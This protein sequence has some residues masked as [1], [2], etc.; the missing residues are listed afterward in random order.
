MAYWN[1]IFK[2]TKAERH[3]YGTLPMKSQF[4]VNFQEKWWKAAND[5]KNPF[6]PLSNIDHYVWCALANVMYHNNTRGCQE[7]TSIKMEDFSIGIGTE[8][9]YAGIPYVQL[10]ANYDNQ[11]G[12][13]LTM[14]KN[15]VNAENS[16]KKCLPIPFDSHP[17]SCYKTIRTL[18]EWM[19]AIE[20]CT[21]TKAAGRRFFRHKASK[22]DLL[23]F[24]SMGMP[25]QL[26][27]NKNNVIGPN[28]VNVILK[29]IAK[30]CGYNNWERCTSHGLRR[31][32]LS[33]CANAGVSSAVMVQLGGHSAVPKEQKMTALYQKP[34]QQAY[35]QA[36]RA[37]HG[38]PS[39]IKEKLAAEQSKKF[40]ADDD[41][42]PDDFDLDDIFAGLNDFDFTA[43]DGK[44][45]KKPSVGFDLDKKPAAVD[46]KPPPFAPELPTIDAPSEE[47]AL[48]DRTNTPQVYTKHVERKL[49]FPYKP[50]P[51]YGHQLK[52]VRDQMAELKLKEQQ[53][54]QQQPPHHYRH[55][56][57][58]FSTPAAQ[59]HYEANRVTQSEAPQFAIR[60]NTGVAV[61]YVQQPHQVQQQQPRIL[62]TGTT[63]QVPYQVQSF[64]PP[65]DH[66][67]N[68]QTPMPVQPPT[69]VHQ[70]F[71]HQP[72]YV[73][74]QQP[75]LV[76]SFAP[77]QAPTTIVQQQQQPTPYFG[78]SQVPSSYHLQQPPQFRWI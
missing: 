48:C 74:H 37:K 16:K 38:S 23:K 75:T 7:P 73:H 62:F 58:D 46:T 71:V 50:T 13:A 55:E 22:K 78:E 8:G 42:N 12:V 19:P 56:Q 3:N 15:V 40:F 25:W 21:E 45:D 76:Q 59:A 54:Q 52:L 34:N 70:Q 51:H 29:K 72:Q 10:N 41:P 77:P 39:A 64:Q 14:K 69:V 47:L 53:L 24:K 11:K 27:P 30:W 33:T 32:G 61:S 68:Y 49:P 2:I 28:N 57:L 35:D 43:V 26:S 67:Q 1:Y 44:E 17:L 66:V 6:N 18:M 31:G 5:P 63:Q 9:D 20:N 36:I 65:P 4:D 60:R